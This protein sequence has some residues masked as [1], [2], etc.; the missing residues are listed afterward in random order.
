MPGARVR[1]RPR[2]GDVLRTY[3]DPAIYLARP[4]MFGLTLDQYRAEWVRRRD[5]GW[6]SWELSTRLPRPDAV[7]A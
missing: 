7:A 2:P 6:Q 1:W 3:P 5:E 4:T